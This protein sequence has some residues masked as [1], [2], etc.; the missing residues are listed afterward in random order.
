MDFLSGIDE[1]LPSGFQGAAKNRLRIAA[2]ALVGIGK[3]LH[4]DHRA[5]MVFET[6]LY[7][8]MPGLTHAE[9]A[10]LALA[11]FSSYSSAS[12][13]PNNAAMKA[14]LSDE[15]RH[16]ARTYGE[17]MRFAV[18]LSGRNSEILSHFR[19]SNESG[20]LTLHIENGFE[21][22]LIERGRLRFQRLARLI[23]VKTNIVITPAD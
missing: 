21:D 18:V 3:G 23:G 5:Q 16:A 11:L 12:S 22:V 13:T 2:C 6:V 17:A 8:P 19:L 14:L 4:P 15:Q 7:A 1:T 9:R 10:C 20:V